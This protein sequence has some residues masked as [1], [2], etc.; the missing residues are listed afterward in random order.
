MPESPQH[1]IESAAVPETTDKEG[2]NVGGDGDQHPPFGNGQAVQQ[3]DDRFEDVD[4]Q[5]GGERNVPTLPKFGNIGRKVGIV[6]VLGGAHTHH[7]GHTY[8]HIAVAGKVDVDVERV[9]QRRCADR[10]PWSKLRQKHLIVNSIRLYQRHNQQGFHCTE[11]DAAHAGEKHPHI[12]PHASGGRPIVEVVECVDGPGHEGREEKEVVEIGQ[13]VAAA[14]GALV[15]LHQPMDDAEEDVRKSEFLHGKEVF[16]KDFAP[17][18]AKPR[19]HQRVVAHRE[20]EDEQGECH[21]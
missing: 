4:F 9:E 11:K 14:E 5:E 10:A 1:K 13:K 8:G 19:L 16:A 6:K 17:P 21:S 20:K 12:E 3:R 2:D 7:V 15:A 18:A